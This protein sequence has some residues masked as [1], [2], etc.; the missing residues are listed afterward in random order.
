MDVYILTAIIASMLYALQMVF[1]KIYIS[2]HKS[3]SNQ[4]I[5]L[6]TLL[7]SGLASVLLLPLVTITVVLPVEYYALFFISGGIYA[8]ATA[9][10]FFALR[11]E[12]AS[13]VSQLTGTEV[14][15][16]A[17]SGIIVFNETISFVRIFGLI[18]IISGIFILIFDRGVARAIVTAKFAVIPVIF[19]VF[20]WAAQDS[21]TNY[22]AFEY[23]TFTLFFWI[24]LSSALFLLPLIL[25]SEIRTQ[26]SSMVFTETY[27]R[28]FKFFIFS[29]GL[30]TIAMFISI[31]SIA[32]GPL[33]IVAPLLGS[34]PIFTLLFGILV[35][36]STKFTIEPITAEHIFS[37]VLSNILFF[38]GIIILFHF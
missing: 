38:S 25:K 20:L 22:I 14:V 9:L 34:Y 16:T 1:D 33:S 21:V 28:N 36:Y 10:W 32:N 8:A 7:F 27:I 2:E 6:F 15:I 18:C 12:N 23:N 11:H 35:T 31:F 19:S 37:R 4:S 5:V 13:K 3:L 30:V 29:R 26:L 17:L 24:R